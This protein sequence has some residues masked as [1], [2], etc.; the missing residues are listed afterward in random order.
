MQIG[1]VA[2]GTTKVTF[3]AG[4][5]KPFVVHVHSHPGADPVVTGISAHAGPA[6][7][8]N[9]VTIIGRNF[10][11]VTGVS[12]GTR[13]GTHVQVDSRT[14]LTV[15]APAGTGDGFVSVTTA[16]GGPS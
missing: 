15:R 1:K 4:D 11:R 6:L 7:G 12:F 5:D 14:K 10:G 3:T 2:P 13:P 16:G 8:G 9:T